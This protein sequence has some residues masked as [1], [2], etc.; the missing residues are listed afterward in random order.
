MRFISFRE[1]DR[2]AQG[3]EPKLPFLH[4]NIFCSTEINPISMLDRGEIFHLGGIELDF[5]F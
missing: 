5:D 4:R 3:D 1:L 2:D